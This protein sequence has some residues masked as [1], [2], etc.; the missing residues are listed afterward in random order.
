MKN[1]TEL[2]VLFGELLH[3][4]PTDV[5]LIGNEPGVHAVSNNALID[6]DNIVLI[7]RQYLWLITMQIM[8]T[9]SVA[10]ITG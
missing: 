2:T 7:K 1:C 3:S 10:D 4:A 8:P 6:P 9:K 5:K